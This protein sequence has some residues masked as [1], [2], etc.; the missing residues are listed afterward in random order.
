MQ[1]MRDLTQNLRQLIVTQ[2]LGA[3]PDTFSVTADQV[4]RLEQ[5]ASGI[6]QVDAVRAIDL[7]AAAQAAAKEGS[8]PRIQLEVALLK[9][10]NPRVD[11]SIDAL[12][13]RIERIE[14][15]TPVVAP[16]ER[17]APPSSKKAKPTSDKPKPQPKRAEPEANGAPKQESPADE[18][19]TVIWPA[20]LE[21]V[22]DSEGGEMLAAL[23]SD[24]R[25]T[26]L[27]DDVLVL[28]YPHS[29]SFSKRKVEDPANGE[30]I[31][32]ALRLV[33]GRPLRI[34]VELTDASA[35]SGEEQPEVD[36]EEL[37]RLV[38]EAFNAEEVTV[39][40]KEPVPNDQPSDD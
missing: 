7:I 29:A 10:A 27:D 19:M 14:S 38:K 40:P 33:A 32:E 23:L 30:R 16:V 2:A 39:V 26:A 13:A 22:R 20:V 11:A 35:E 5:Q 21:R 15:G 18:D 8:D 17:A 6:K 1:F 34:K 3:V 24:A 25:P 4:E 9:A 31:G 37:V 12:F 28:A 36:E